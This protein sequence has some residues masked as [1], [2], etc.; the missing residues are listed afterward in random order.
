MFTSSIKRVSVNLLLYV[1]CFQIDQ[2]TVYIKLY[3]SLTD[4]QKASHSQL[5]STCYMYT[6]MIF[7]NITSFLSY[8]TKLVKHFHS[9]LILIHLI[10]IYD[11][12]LISLQFRYSI[13]DD[14]GSFTIYVFQSVVS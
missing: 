4:S 1:P 6:F 12:S 13:K 2:L 9:S 3:I 14:R 10:I 8:V 11:N 5:F 7:H